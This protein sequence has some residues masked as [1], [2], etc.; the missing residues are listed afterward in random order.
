M[1]SSLRVTHSPTYVHT[2]KHNNEHVCTH[3]AHTSTKQ[4]PFYEKQCKGSKKTN[5]RWGKRH[6]SDIINRTFNKIYKDLKI[7]QLENKRP[8]QPECSS[9]TFWQRREP[10]PACCLLIFTHCC[11]PHSHTMHMVIRH[12]KH[13]TAA[14]K[15]LEWSE[16]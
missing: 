14:T 6:F 13:V 11:D 16:S 10:S 12:H 7:Q 1:L 8:W 15:L 3:A 2:H 5:H 9:Q 4:P